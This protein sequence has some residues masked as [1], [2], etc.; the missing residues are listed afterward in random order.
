M[1]A[2]IDIKLHIPRFDELSYRQKLMSDPATMSYNRGYSLDFAGYHRDTGCIDFPPQAWPGWYESWI[3]RESERFY[4]YIAADGRFAGEVCLHSAD[5]GRTHELG[6]LIEASRRGE[7]LAKPAL[8]LLIDRA[9]TVLGSEKLTNCFEPE[10]K[11]ALR[12]HTELGFEAESSG[13][14]LLLTLTRENYLK[15][16]L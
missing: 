2:P 10:R 9:F 5:G 7:G 4:A 8:R 12:I 1:K 13:G 3:G 16:R 11:A 14:L 15:N 6:I